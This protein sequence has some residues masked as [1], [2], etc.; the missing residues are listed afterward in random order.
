M[1]NRED[2]EWTNCWWSKANEEVDRILLV[3]DSVIRGVRGELEK[4]MENQY[5]VDLFATSLNIEDDLF[6][7]HLWL[8]M[9]TKEYK[10]KGIIVQ[11]GFHHGFYKKCADSEQDRNDF[12]A[13]YLKLLE[14]MKKYCSNIILMTGNSEVYAEQPYRLNE[15]REREIVCR[16]RIASIAAEK[17][18]C[19]VFDMYT[20]MHKVENDYQ[21]VDAQHYVK[22]A[23][24]YIAYELF[25]FLHKNHFIGTDNMINIKKKHRDLYYK[26]SD[27]R[28]K[29][30]IYGAGTNGKRLYMML[31]KYFYEME[32]IQFA[33]SRV[34]GEKWCLKQ[35]VMAIDEITAQ[36]KKNAVLVLSSPDYYQEMRQTAVELQFDYIICYED[37]IKWFEKLQ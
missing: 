9:E 1:R 26:W 4:L 6:W 3:G 25:L 33:E 18:G 2:I 19:H 10:Y 36:E 14:L 32:N 27:G 11:Y 24:L 20:I 35:K 13:Q 8:F 21:Y 34:D 29:I 31:K 23:D 12:G 30:V 5:G 37:L 28:E 22:D 7:R 15:E 16:N 17:T